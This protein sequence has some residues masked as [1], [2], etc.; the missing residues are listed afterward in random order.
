MQ[1]KGNPLVSA[2]PTY[3]W[4]YLIELND[5]LLHI[6]CQSR[7]KDVPYC[8]CFYIDEEFICV[9]PPNCTTSCVLR[10]TCTPIFVKSTM[11]KGIINSNAA[12]EAKSIWEGYQE[13]IKKN[14]H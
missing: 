14:G 10:V 7:A 13:F 3:K 1:I 12:K 11:M 9:M 8:D 2:T 5:N 4:L 6:R